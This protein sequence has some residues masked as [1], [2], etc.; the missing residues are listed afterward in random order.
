M[1]QASQPLMIILLFTSWIIMAQLPLAWLLEKSKH[2]LL[3]SDGS[4]WNSCWNV[5]PNVAMVGGGAFKKWLN[6]EG[7]ASWIIN[8][9]L[10]SWVDVL[11]GYDGS[12]LVITKVG[13]FKK[14]GWLSLVD[15]PVRVPTSKKALIRCGPET[16]DFPASRRIKTKFIFFINSPVSVI[17]L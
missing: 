12:G 7:W 9:L 10:L 13:L 4:L 14:S 6:Y 16:M 11:M 15:S 17:H 1:S 3:W 5:I 8:W 2:T